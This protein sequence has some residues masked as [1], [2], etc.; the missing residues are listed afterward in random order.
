MK[1]KRSEKNMKKA[2]AKRPGQVQQGGYHPEQVLGN[3][4]STYFELA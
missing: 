3:A 1:K 4:K 2:P